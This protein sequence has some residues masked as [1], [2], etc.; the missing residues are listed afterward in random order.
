MKKV[1]SYRKHIQHEYNITIVKIVNFFVKKYIKSF[2][3]N[4]F[5]IQKENIFQEEYQTVFVLNHQSHLDY[6]LSNHLFFESFQSKKILIA[7]GENLNFFPIGDLLRSSGA[8][9]IKRT[10]NQKQY[11]QDFQ[12]YLLEIMNKENIIEFFIEGSRSR[13]GQVLKPKLGFLKM[14]ME[15][16]EGL[17]IIP[18]SL[19]HSFI[20]EQKEFIQEKKDNIKNKENFIG[21]IKN[22][23]FKKKLGNFSLVQGNSIIITS[24]SNLKEKS[25]EIYKELNENK[26]ITA[27]DIICCLL[28]FHKNYSLESL[29]RKF[30]VFVF[31]FNLMKKK[32]L[33]NMSFVLALEFL[34]KNKKITIQEDDI[35]IQDS[36]SMQYNF[37]SFLHC[38]FA[39]ALLA[40]VLVLFEKNIIKNFYDVKKYV[41]FK[42]QEIN[43]L[44]YVPSFKELLSQGV[45]LFDVLKKRKDL[46]SIADYLEPFYAY[47]Y[48]S[49]PLSQEEVFLDQ[50]NYKAHWNEL[51]DQKKNEYLHWI[52][53]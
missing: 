35:S 16:S 29:E 50:K 14:M 2:Y 21:L 8:F 18:F 41:F 6:L 39:P 25:F 43:H 46:Y 47:F 3:E 1:I 11:K 40:H 28:A 27:I 36:F 33:G 20:F 30:H 12:D 31:I 4:I 48:E 52:V 51:K 22:I 7:A 42:K 23:F 44:F 13:Y 10:F 9:Y 15:S 34:I 5:F 26:G 53:Q 37:N 24:K 38:F 19:H 45:F 32:L 49:F 17:N